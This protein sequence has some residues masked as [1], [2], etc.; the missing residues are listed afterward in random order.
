MNEE[1]ASKIRTTRHMFLEGVTMLLSKES[2][3]HDDGVVMWARNMQ[4]AFTILK[5]TNDNGG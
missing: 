4:E 5:Q 3:R 2:L 1:M